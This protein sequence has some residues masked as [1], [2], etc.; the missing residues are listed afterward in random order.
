MASI[1]CWAG[2][3]WR[4]ICRCRRASRSPITTP[5]RP[6]WAA[7]NMTARARP[8]PPARTILHVPADHPTIAAALAA[9]GGSGVVEI[10]DSGRYEETLAVTV[11]AGG[12]VILR[13][14]DRLPADAHPRRRADD[15]RR[16]RQRLQ[17]WR[18]CWSPA[19]ACAYP[20]PPATSW[21]G[22]TIAHATLRAG[23]RPRRRRQSGLTGRG[24]PSWWSWPSVTVEIDHAILGALRLPDGDEPHRHGFASSTPIA[25]DATAYCAPDGTSAGG[26]LSLDRLHRHRRGSAPARWNSSPTACCW[27]AAAGGDTL[28]PV[29]AVRRQTGCV[30][31]T[32]LPFA[33]LTPAAL[34]LSAGE[35]PKANPTL[36]RASPRCATAS[37]PIAS[38]SRSSPDEIRR[39]ADDESEM[40]AF[41]ALFPAAARGQSAGPAAGVPARRAVGR[42]LL[43]EL[44]RARHE[45]RL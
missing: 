11:N 22:C 23:P 41:H 25:P 4:P 13:A 6:I 24:E 29:Y 12:H 2:S 32:F 28:P 34:S 37:P 26:E 14:A 40:G 10:T 16:R 36:P 17:L 8:M 15:H 3:R 5:S 31:F 42:R 7:A 35:L 30:R 27:R 21:H 39:G 18:A 9:L 43:R 33:S 20:V 19:R 38:S 45:L 44:R 1:P